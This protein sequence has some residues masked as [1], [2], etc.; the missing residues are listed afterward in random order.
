MVGGI[1][2]LIAGSLAS[3]HLGGT[4][5]GGGLKQDVGIGSTY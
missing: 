4:C 1:S 3:D 2:Y 5:E